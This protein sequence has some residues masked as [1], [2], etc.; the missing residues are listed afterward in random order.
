M[1]YLTGSRANS[2]TMCE[3][4]GVGPSELGAPGVRFARSIDQTFASLRTREA[5]ADLRLGL[6]ARQQLQTRRFSEGM[7]LPL[8]GL[9]YNLSPP[10]RVD[11][12]LGQVTGRLPEVCCITNRGAGAS[13]R[14]ARPL[15]Q[16]Q[17]DLTEPP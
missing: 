15:E 1:S 5:T 17:G 2:S 8:V 9:T 7:T 14:E 10:P 11:L 12:D 4:V 16:D 3:I 13:H 6:M